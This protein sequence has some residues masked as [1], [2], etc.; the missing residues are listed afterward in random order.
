MIVACIV[1]KRPDLSWDLSWDDQETY[2]GKSPL[3]A[4]KR[5]KG[6]VFVSAVPRN[7]SHKILR[8][9]VRDN[10]IAAA[11]EPAAIHRVAA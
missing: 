11:T 7:A 8:R 1:K 6:H 9:L 5:P 4:F 3:A 2:C 10:A